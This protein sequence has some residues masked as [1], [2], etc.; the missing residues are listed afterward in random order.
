MTGDITRGRR[1]LASCSNAPITHPHRAQ[2]TVTKTELGASLTCRGNCIGFIL[3]DSHLALTGLPSMLG[4]LMH[5]SF[6]YC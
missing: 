5:L 2:T 6:D 4:G 1:K 3:H